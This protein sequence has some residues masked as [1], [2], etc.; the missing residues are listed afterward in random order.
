MDPIFYLPI[1]ILANFIW[2]ELEYL[3]FERG[4]QL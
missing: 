2:L 1:I 3:F 4:Y